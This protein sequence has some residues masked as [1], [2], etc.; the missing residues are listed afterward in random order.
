MLVKQQKMIISNHLELYDLIITEDN[1]WRQIKEMIDFQFIYNELADKYCDNNGRPAEDP[2]MMFKLLLIK[3]VDNLSDVKLIQNLRV[4]MAYKYFLDLAPEETNFI[5]PSLLTK[6]RRQ[7]L[8]DVEILDLLIGKTVK[9]AIEKGIIKERNKIIV[10]STHTVSRYGQISPR[11]ALINVSKELRKN[12]YTFNP[13]MKEKMPKKREASGILEDEIKYCEE[14][15][16]VLEENGFDEDF[17]SSAVTE[18]LSLLKEMIE[19][20][21]YKLAQSKDQDAKVGHKT[22]DTS[23]FG[24]KTHIAMTPERIITGV[25]VTSGEV[26]DGKQ[27]E[28]L[29]EAS[30]KAGIKVTEVIGDAAY[31][32]KDNIEM[33]KKRKIKLV[34]KLCENITHSTH[35]KKEY[36]FNK[37][38]GMYVCPEGHMAIKKYI[39]RHKNGVKMSDREAY[40]FDI[41]KCKIC[42]RKEGCYKE[43][44][45][46]KSYTVTIKSDAHKAQEEFQNTEFFKKEYSERYKIESK[47]G[48]LKQVYGYD[49]A[50]SEGLL[51]MEIQGALSIFAANMKRII[52]L[53]TEK[54]KK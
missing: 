1:M 15:I 12:V 37:D 7:R 5:D 17:I 19:D 36:E 4:N 24:Y 51:G 27:L 26:H 23:F 25:K 28:D 20:N 29:I 11:Q 10:D 42:P 43:G 46:V 13:A 40:Y 6:F 21:N 52:K 38:A 47:N 33:T 49:K 50:Q 48:E 22:A 18:K 54:D 3:C 35:G 53:S 34:A 14:L 41:E 16:K 45:K 32:D 31:S 2:I 39:I 9:L 44:A 30:E 8:K